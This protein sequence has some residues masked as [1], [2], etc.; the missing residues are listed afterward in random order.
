VRFI[1]E[2]DLRETS[3]RS[4][5][6]KS[7]V[8][9]FFICIIIIIVGFIIRSVIGYIPD[10]D[11][12]DPGYEEYVNLMEILATT[13]ILLQN[14]GISLFSLATFLGAVSDGT[15]SKQVRRGLAIASGIGLIALI[16]FGA[17]FQIMYVVM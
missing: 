14:T 1:S 10:V 4:N 6:K 16:I 15:L 7:Y 8:K 17:S 11:F 9:I 13:S 5:L 12:G 2:V 3:F